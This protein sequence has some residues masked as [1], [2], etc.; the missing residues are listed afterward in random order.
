MLQVLA[1]GVAHEDHLLQQFA[2]CIHFGNGLPEDEQQLLE[3]VIVR[4][5]AE[6]DHVH[7]HA[8]QIWRTLPYA[9]KSW[10]GLWKW[11]LLNLDEK[12]TLF[13]LHSPLSVAFSQGFNNHRDVFYWRYRNLESVLKTENKVDREWTW[14]WWKAPI[15]WKERRRNLNS[16]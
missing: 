2:L 10:R 1:I 3:R 4:R 8:L 13:S 6:T 15:L 9:Q 12:A 7:Q 14:K 16:S 11:M 5:Q